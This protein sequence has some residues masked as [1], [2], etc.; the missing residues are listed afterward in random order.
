M[1]KRKEIFQTSRKHLPSVEF[2]EVQPKKGAS[3]SQ[4]IQQNPPESKSTSFTHLAT[5]TKN[6]QHQEDGRDE[7]DMH[8][9]F[10]E[11]E[12]LKDE[13]MEDYEAN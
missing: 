6:S 10:F 8:L 3:N 9:E 7:D 5:F 13:E 1:S 4:T 12:K 2:E 11:L